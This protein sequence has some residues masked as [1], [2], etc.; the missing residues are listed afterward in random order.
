M[1]T[2]KEFFEQ[3]LHN[4]TQYCHANLTDIKYQHLLGLV[5]KI[6]SS[7]IKSALMYFYQVVKPL[8]PEK[9]FE[10]ILYQ[11]NLRETD[12]EPQHLHKIKLYIECFLAIV[13]Q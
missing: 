7:S 1:T 3:K 5:R 4:F 12:F 6:Y 11:T 2:N 9:Y 8:G 10:R 13:D